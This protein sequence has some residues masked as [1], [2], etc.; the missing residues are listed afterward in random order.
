MVELFLKMLRF[1]FPEVD[2]NSWAGIQLSSCSNEPVLYRRYKNLTTLPIR[3]ID[4]FKDHL[5]ADQVAEGGVVVPLD[6]GELML[7]ENSCGLWT[8]AFRA[9]IGMID[10][11]SNEPWSQVLAAG[12]R[13]YTAQLG[14]TY[15]MEP[16]RPRDG[17]WIQMQ[18]MK[19]EVELKESEHVINE[20]P[21]SI[22]DDG[23]IIMDGLRDEGGPDVTLDDIECRAYRDYYS[24]E[25]WETKQTAGCW[26][27]T[28][29]PEVW[30]EVV[31]MGGL[32]EL[33]TG[34]DERLVKEGR[35]PV[36]SPRSVD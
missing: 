14:T 32:D 2:S 33:P 29:A 30:H 9:A 10:L 15:Y 4:D 28:V 6:P 34:P 26:V 23:S 21:P 12:T 3:F 16:I 24:L 35:G 5:P 19:A 18:P 17:L 20:P 7:V 8:M 27:R 22:T 31:T 13:N 1:R 11:I 36:S 25:V